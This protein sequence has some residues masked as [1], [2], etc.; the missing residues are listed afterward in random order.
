MVSEAE[1]LKAAIAERDLAT[2][3]KVVNELHHNLVRRVRLAGIQS[4]MP[5]MMIWRNLL[6]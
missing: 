5:D 6:K 2:M 4:I 3:T 1:Q